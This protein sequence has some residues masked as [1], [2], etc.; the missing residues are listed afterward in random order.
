MND[1]MK[2]NSGKSD[3][4][5]GAGETKA[6]SGHELTSS[7][8]AEVEES[9]WERIARLEAAVTE[10]T[11]ESDALRDRLLRLV[12][13]TD[14]YK[15]RAE[16]ERADAITL[17][18]E[19]LI[20]EILPVLDNL[21]RAFAHAEGSGDGKDS[22]HEGVKLTLEQLRG[23]L[24]K[25]GVAEVKAVGEKFDPALHHAI[26]HEEA[27]GA[28]AGTVVKEFQKGYFLKGRLLRPSMVAVAKE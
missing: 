19:A 10:K 11:K 12:A 25:F 16:K 5:S 21:E 2:K 15:K 18:N 22:L 13:D 27:D 17:A 1:N 20:S 4:T 24:R 23:V 26:S 14:N 3:E 8:T 6:E 28:G 9:G 7:D